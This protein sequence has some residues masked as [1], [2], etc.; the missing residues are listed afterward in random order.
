MVMDGQII[1]YNLSALDTLHSAVDPAIDFIDDLRGAFQWHFGG[2]VPCRQDSV[3]L[4]S[5]GVCVLA[6]G[7]DFAHPFPTLALKSARWL[8]R[9]G[10]LSIVCVIQNVFAC[11][12]L[13]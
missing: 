2:S 8:S 5:V 4:V 6:L 9:L 7:H 10:A 13:L 12:E 3:E 1:F 11:P